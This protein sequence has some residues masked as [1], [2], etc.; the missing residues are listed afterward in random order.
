L[1]FNLFGSYSAYFWLLDR[2]PPTLIATH[3]YVNP[4]V[5]LVLGWT[6]AGEALTASFVFGGLVIIAAIALVGLLT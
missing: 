2:F 1:G 5:A 3:T 6:I 4:L